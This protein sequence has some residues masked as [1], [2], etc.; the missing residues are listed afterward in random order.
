MNSHS[1]IHSMRP[2][3]A[4]TV[5]KAWLA[6]QRASN[7]IDH[8]S[9]ERV[10]R[11]MWRA[12][13]DWLAAEQIPWHGVDTS[14]LARF[15]D[16]PA[17]GQHK[18]RTPRN[19]ARMANY[20]HQRYW[21]LIESVYAYATVQNWIDINPATTL[22]PEQRPRINATSRIAQILPPGVLALLRS[23]DVLC[24]VLPLYSER[25]WWRM[26]DRAIV[27]L[28]AHT[29]LT[30]SELITL[31][32]QDLRVHGTHGLG[33]T[34]L[35]LPDTGAPNQHT[36]WLDVRDSAHGVS[37]SLALPE[38]VTA[39]LRPWLARRLHL[40]AAH[41]AHHTSPIVERG[42]Y[43]RKHDRAGS[44]FPSR[45]SRHADQPLP[46][47]RPHSLHRLISA[48]LDALY[49]SRHATHLDRR[50]DGIQIGHGSA[51]IRNSVMR[52]WLDTL[53]IDATIELAGLKNAGSLR[54]H[55]NAG[56]H[57]G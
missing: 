1:P 28:L 13:S 32:G 37:R 19:R 52:V 31:Q 50:V 40:L 4:E 53:G 33:A 8:D 11:G 5:F 41:H 22:A 36:L 48:T 26:R 7:I 54:L 45:E 55:L 47:M 9:S 29:A 27:A 12:W 30:S 2:V 51:I 6:A 17:P 10:Y 18:R 46:I 14:T 34:Q 25:Q 43:V 21:H 20:T 39:L 3:N 57:A 15:L 16:G 42:T 44:L 23:P 38:P 35:C 24:D 49:S 56:R